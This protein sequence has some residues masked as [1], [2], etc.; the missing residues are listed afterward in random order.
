MK[1]K[2]KNLNAKDVQ[3]TSL[4]TLYAMNEILLTTARREAGW[5]RTSPLPWNSNV[6]DPK[7]N[8]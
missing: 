7:R 6:S 3:F 2:G 5:A 1:T 8:T 4:Q